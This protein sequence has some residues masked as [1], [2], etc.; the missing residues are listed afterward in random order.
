MFLR[1]LYVHILSTST[2]LA[3]YIFNYSIHYSRMP[4]RSNKYPL[5]GFK[6]KKGL[7]MA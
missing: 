2:L 6:K 5:K 4:I 1:S 7:I 3:L